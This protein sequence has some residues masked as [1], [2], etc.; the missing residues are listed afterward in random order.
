MNK[1]TK[2]KPGGGHYLD[3]PG[4]DVQSLA[5]NL[6]RTMNNKMAINTYLSTTKP[7]NQARK[8]RRQ[9]QGYKECFD[10]LP[11]GGG[12]G[13]E[14]RGLGSTN[15]WLQNSHGAVKYS[16]GKGVAK[17]RIFMHDP[18]TRTMV[19]GWPEGVGGAGWR[20]KKGK[21]WDNCNSIIHEINLK[22]KSCD[23]LADRDLNLNS[24]YLLS[25]SFLTY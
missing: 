2:E 11:L 14:V 19:Q 24:C 4:T 23:V 17:E 16:V 9:N 21:D 12:M 25:L 20:G 13:E 1:N 8:K 10:W 3:K 15:R 18:C 22:K 6:N 7:K 5:Q